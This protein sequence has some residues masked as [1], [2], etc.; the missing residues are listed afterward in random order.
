MFGSLR[1][2]RRCATAR[3]R[4]RRRSPARSRRCL[5]ALPSARRAR[6]SRAPAPS[7]GVTSN[8][9]GRL[10]AVRVRLRGDVGGAAH[11]LVRRVGAAA[12]QRGRDRIDK[13]VPASATSAASLRD[14]ARAVRRVRADD[15][16]LERRRDRARARGRSTRSGFGL[17]LRVRR[18]QVLDCC[19][20]SGTSVAAA[21]RAQIA[22]H[23]LVGTGRSKSWRRAPRPCW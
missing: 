8:G 9:D 18:E 13:A 20:T 22:R 5:R 12:D 2:R 6:S 17:D 4:D 10:E 3:C 14:R 21:G 7:P 23:A 15:V 19:S 11:V 1:R 16:R